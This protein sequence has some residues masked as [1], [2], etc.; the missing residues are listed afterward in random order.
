MIVSVDSTSKLPIKRGEV[1]FDI[2]KDKGDVVVALNYEYDTK[3]GPVGRLMGP[4][5]DKQLSS[6]FEGFL[7][8]LEKAAVAESV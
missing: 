1:T 3:F 8:D 6:G 7:E 4:M 2:T 5:L